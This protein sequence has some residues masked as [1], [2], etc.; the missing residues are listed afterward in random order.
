[1]TI[2]GIIIAV[3]GILAS[4]YLGIW[5]M[6]AGGIISLIDIVKTGNFESI[7]IAKSIVKIIFAG[8]CSSIGIGISAFI[9]KLLLIKDRIK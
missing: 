6:F 7:I 8:T 3:A 4:L 5:V 2:L 9:G 1:M